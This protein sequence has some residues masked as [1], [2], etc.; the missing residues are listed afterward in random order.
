MKKKYFTEE[1][2]KEHQRQY[3]KRYRQEHKEELAEKKKQYWNKHR[4]EECEKKRQRYQEHKEEHIEKVKQWH[5]EHKKEYAEWKKQWSK[6]YRQTQIG[7]ASGRLQSYK[8]SDKKQNRGECTIPNAQWIV[9]NIFTN[10]CHWC[11]ETDWHKLG[12]D[13]IDNTKPHTPDNVIP[14]CRDCNNKRHT[15]TYEEFKKALRAKETTL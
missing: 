12:C 6:E 7:I 1:E 10:P 9:E 3:M 5:Q 14:C 8:R 15:M 4:D 2:R 13:R 11:G